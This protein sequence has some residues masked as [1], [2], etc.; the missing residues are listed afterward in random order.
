MSDDVLKQEPSDERA[1][2]LKT[3][4]LANLRLFPVSWFRPFPSAL[5]QE[6]GSPDESS[7]SW[8]AK[9]SSEGR[10][11]RRPYD[12]DGGMTEQREELY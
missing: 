1:A 8:V 11:K 12:W 3:D 10:S 2:A 4:L 9:P 7:L 6:N 5:H